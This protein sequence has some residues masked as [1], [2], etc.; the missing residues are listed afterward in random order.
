MRNFATK[1]S[2]LWKYKVWLTLSALAIIIT[3]AFYSLWNGNPIHLP[4]VPTVL[5]Y[6]AI[7]ITWFCWWAFA[8][9]CPECGKCYAWHY[10]NSGNFSNM[11]IRQESSTKCPSCGFEPE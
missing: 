4:E 3:I 2:Q 1:T 6:F 10:M 8:I 11:L 7:C 9:R 5:A